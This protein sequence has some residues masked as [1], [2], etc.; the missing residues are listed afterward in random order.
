MGGRVRF[1]PHDDGP[2]PPVTANR[3]RR[4]ADGLLQLLQT[5]VER[6]STVPNA[7]AAGLPGL[8]AWPKRLPRSI[9]LAVA[10]HSLSNDQDPVGLAGRFLPL[11]Q[12]DPSTNH[13]S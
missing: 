4:L 1:V 10:A 9:L 2:L 7:G 13:Y 8:A 5:A 12:W 6:H 11:L 3:T